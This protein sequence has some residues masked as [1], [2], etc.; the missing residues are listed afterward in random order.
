MDTEKI[1]RKCTRCKEIK[2]ETNFKCYKYKGLV[3]RVKNCN[4]CIISK[5]S[6]SDT[7]SIKSW[8]ETISY[9]GEEIPLD[10]VFEV[11]EEGQYR[12]KKS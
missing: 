7:S 10:I 2:I 9:D 1:Y 8:L 4:S 5:D 12:Y 3:R 6:F 11:N